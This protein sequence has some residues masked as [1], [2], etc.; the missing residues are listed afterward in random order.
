MV[1]DIHHP[2]PYYAFQLSHMEQREGFPT[3]IGVFRAWGHLPN[4]ETVI[5]DQIDAV[6]AKKGPGDLRKLLQSGDTWTV[7]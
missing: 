6:I 4:F 1:H 3:P 5:N 2:R 7:K